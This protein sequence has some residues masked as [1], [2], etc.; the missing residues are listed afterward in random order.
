MNPFQ[1][2]GI[3][4]EYIVSMSQGEII[5]FAEM[6]YKTFQ[7]KFHP[8]VNFG[9]SDISNQLNEAISLIRNPEAYEDALLEHISGQDFIKILK[10]KIKNSEN[11]ISKLKN[12]LEI[13]Q[14]TNDRRVKDLKKLL[15]LYIKNIT[16][17][18]KRKSRDFIYISELDG[19]KISYIYYT[20][21]DK[22]VS[23][24]IKHGR[25]WYYNKI[26]GPSILSG[27]IE[28]GNYIEPPKEYEFR[29]G[30]VGFSLTHEQFMQCFAMYLKPYLKIGNYIV[31]SK[32]NLRPQKTN[33]EGL[34]TSIERQE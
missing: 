28:P 24:I 17:P 32:T 18:E 14:S 9:K 11:E 20:P 19:Y 1:A 27:S 6:Q 2:L 16:V 8:D 7:K 5:K 25:V 10:N 23:I 33:I 34:I 30:S 21:E 29:E 31:I 12:E 15:Q 13:S 3:P 22:E 26:E 4:K